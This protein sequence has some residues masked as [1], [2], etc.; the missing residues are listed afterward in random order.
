MEPARAPVTSLNPPAPSDYR[1]PAAD[2]QP[3]FRYWRHRLLWSTYFGY[4]VFYLMRKNLSIALPVMQ[5]QLNVN[6]ST[7]GTIFMLNDLSYGFAKFVAGLWADRYNPRILLVGGMLVSAITNLFFG[8]GASVSVLGALWVLNG[9]AQGFGFPP[10][11]RILSYWFHPRERG[12]YWGVFNTSHQVGTMAILVLGAYLAGHFGW[13]WAFW[14]P[15]MVG[16]LTAAFLWDRVRDTPNS[17]GLPSVEVY[18]ELKQGR[19]A[20]YLQEEQPGPIGVAQAETEPGGI[21]S[22]ADTRADDP[23]EIIRRYVWRNPAVWLVCIGNFFVYVVRMSFL[24]WAPTY[25]KTV[26]GV[27]LQNAGNLTTSYEFAGLI[28]CLLSGWITDRFFAGRRAPACVAWMALCAVFVYL[29][30]KTQS[31][32][33]LV[34]GFYLAGVGFAVYGPQFLVGV[35]VADLATKRAAGTA[36]GL[37]GLC[38]YLSGILSGGV[39]S[40]IVDSY[41]W[42]A[43]FIM[44]LSASVLACV[45]FLLTWNAKP[46]IEPIE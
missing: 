29:F 5:Q 35:M 15:A 46:V 17:L 31:T 16:L 23:S 8:F 30:W 3:A 18:Q 36:V 14:V 34:Y 26:K 6:L 25:L 39:L 41:G 45:P 4:A 40:R 27:S 1:V 10:C 32:N 13:Q 24:N 11:A 19:G 33:P 38:G 21:G 2:V 37:S 22:V 7:F 43:G 20:E 42:D 44:I 12:L 28:G 9:M